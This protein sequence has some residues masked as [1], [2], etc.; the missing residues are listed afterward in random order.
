MAFI[1]ILKSLQRKTKKREAEGEYPVVYIKRYE[2]VRWLRGLLGKE[3]QINIIK[4]D[5]WDRLNVKTLY[6]DNLNMKIYENDEN[7]NHAC[8]EKNV[9]LLK[10]FVKKRKH[11]L[12]INEVVKFI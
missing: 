1:E 4:L 3:I 9:I 7:L 12:L 2:K 10:N 8:A 11:C 5:Y 6:E